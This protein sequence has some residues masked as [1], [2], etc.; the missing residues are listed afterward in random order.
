[1]LWAALATLN[2]LSNLVQIWLLEK[3]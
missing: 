3:T 2:L 1:M